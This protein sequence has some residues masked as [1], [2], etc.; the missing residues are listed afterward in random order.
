[1]DSIRRC[2]MF[3]IIIVFFIIFSV[4]SSGPSNEFSEFGD[5]FPESRKALD[6]CGTS[7]TTMYNYGE[8]SYCCSHCMI[9]PLPDDPSKPTA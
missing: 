2:S 9:R 5:C 8:A 4:V 6:C 3:S 7:Y 1:M